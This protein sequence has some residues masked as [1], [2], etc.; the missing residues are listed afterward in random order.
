MAHSPHCQYIGGPLAKKPLTSYLGQYAYWWTVEEED[1]LALLSGR[2]PTRRNPRRLP[3]GRS[4]GRQ[5]ADHN[6]I[7]ADGKQAV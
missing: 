1:I 4:D 7:I 5:K 3:E 2:T 6:P